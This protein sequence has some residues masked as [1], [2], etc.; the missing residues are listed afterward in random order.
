M[1]AGDIVEGEVSY[2]GS[3]SLTV[4]VGN[5]AGLLLARDYDWLD[6][7]YKMSQSKIG[8]RIKAVVTKVFQNSGQMN[9]SAKELKP[10]PFV[11]SADKI[12]EEGYMITHTFPERER[13]IWANLSGTKIILKLESGFSVGV[14]LEDSLI[15]EDELIEGKEYLF[16][17]SKIDYGQRI[18]KLE[19]IGRIN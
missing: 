6:S 7:S 9:L 1:K 3:N 15:P 13:G 19:L 2:I 18:I 16:Y 5:Y 10:D 12:V 17:A 11:I 14:S 4:R 8:D